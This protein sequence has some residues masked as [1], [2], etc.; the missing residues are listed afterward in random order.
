MALTDYH[1]ALVTGASSGI[2][3]AVV[4]ALAGQG[5]TVHAAARRGD[6]LEELAGETGCVPH[7]VDVRDT[8]AV[9]R[10]FG[11]VEVDVLVNNAGLGRGYD[12]F[13]HASRDDIDRTL[14]TN[15]RAATHVLRAIL[16]GM[17]E[18]GRGHVVNLG[19]IAGL[20]PVGL[21][22][23]GASKGA[24][25]LLSGNLRQELKGT[26]VRLTEICP[27]R[28]LTEY[29][30]TALDDPLAREAMTADID[31]LHPEDIAAA[32]VY[33]VDTPWRVNVSLLELMPTEQTTG[34]VQ[35][36]PVKRG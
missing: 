35:T 33:A 2:G 22:I 14:D 13:I 28:V 26:G 32:I 11:S 19:S 10:A 24:M 16:P 5:L 29:F 7:I 30:E 27:G 4:R 23:Y 21:S 12:G 15:V 25:H 6:R 36:V 31:C 17:V 8:D 20:V 3:A 9:Y 1:T 34:G 18:R